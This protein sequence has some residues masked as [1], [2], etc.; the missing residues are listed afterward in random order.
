VRRLIAGNMI[1]LGVMWLNLEA[2]AWKRRRER[3]A[4]E[5]RARVRAF[6]EERGI[7]ADEADMTESQPSAR[8]TDAHGNVE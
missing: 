6:L 4:A 1:V 8:R 5:E 3:D 2:R 7:P